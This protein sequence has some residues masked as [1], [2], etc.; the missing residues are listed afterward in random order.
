VV[1]RNTSTHQRLTVITG[2][3]EK[4]P[5]EQ[6]FHIF[7]VAS[8]LSLPI[9]QSAIQHIFSCQTAL[10]EDSIDSLSVALL[11]AVKVAVEEDQSAGLNLLD[12]L[13]IGLTDKVSY[14]PSY[15]HKEPADLVR[16]GD[17]L[18]VKSS[19]HHPS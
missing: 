11:N 5:E 1:T 15:V 8:E 10:A 13:N 2:L 19:T 4:S 3:A 14:V 17:T 16:Y 12:N 7:K 9:C 18:N 6:I